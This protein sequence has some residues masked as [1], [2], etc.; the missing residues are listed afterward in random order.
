VPLVEVKGWSGTRLRGGH[1]VLLVIDRSLSAWRPTG[2]DIDGDGE[3]GE[4]RVDSHKYDHPFWTTDA[5]DTIYNAEVIAAGKLIERLD[6]KSVRMGLV[7][8]A[9]GGQ[10]RAPLGSSPF[11]LAGALRRLPTRGDEG[12][13]NFR[14][15]VKRAI[16]EFER[17]GAGEKR[18]R[19]LML[20]SDGFPSTGKTQQGE[21]VFVEVAA[22]RAADANVRI[23]G[24]AI[25]ADAVQRPDALKLLTSR[26]GGELML[27]EDPGDVVD[28]MPYTSLTGVARVEIDNLSTSA[29]A[30]TVR[31][32]PD[33]SFDAYAP[34]HPGLNILR[35]TAYGEGG[36]TRIVDRRIH[37]EQIPAD[38]EER[39]AE[40][41]RLLRELRVRTIEME[42]AERAREK[43]DQ[44]RW[45]ELEIQVE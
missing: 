44:I 20:L 41:R 35:V 1:D 37:F 34:L 10:V 40:A 12:G 18:H 21:R 43:R 24:F 4:L 22:K 33:G 2:A 23:Y 16:E 29:R 11:Q 38:T 6:P 17:A 7:T 42:L 36:G 3:I 32:F 8:F 13:T 9:G 14:V 25:G 45:R 19:S 15:S 26:T 27:V 30:R 39:E 5:G 31:V 28:V